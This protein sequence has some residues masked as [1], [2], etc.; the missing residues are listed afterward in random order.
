MA[1]KLPIPT[2]KI[3]TKRFSFYHFLLASPLRTRVFFGLLNLI[4]NLHN[5]Y[6]NGVPR[7]V[8]NIAGRYTR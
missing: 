2:F 7:N 6:I 4:D 3:E 5:F 8:S 1:K